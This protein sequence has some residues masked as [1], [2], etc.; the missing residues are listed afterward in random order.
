[1][2]RYIFMTNYLVVGSDPGT[3]LAQAQKLGVKVLTED[4]FLKL[5]S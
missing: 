3:K 2:V 1:M 5:I 4:S